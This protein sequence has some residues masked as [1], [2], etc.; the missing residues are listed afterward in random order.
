MVGE[1]NTGYMSSF[2][3]NCL[4]T[5]PESTGNLIKLEKLWLCNCGINE[6]PSSLC[7]L[8]NLRQFLFH[9]NPCIEIDQKFLECWKFLE[10]YSIG[11]ANK[12]ETF[13]KK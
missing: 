6:L 5:V 13:E 2:F 8:V 11:E 12:Y 7:K 3:K 4:C 10:N 9:G 1:S